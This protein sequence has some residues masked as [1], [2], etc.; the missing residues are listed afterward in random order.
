VTRPL[1][2]ATALAARLGPRALV[3]PCLAFEVVPSPRPE[4]PGA[5]LLVASPRA[6]QAL[7][8]AGLDPTWRV[9]AL[10]PATTVALRAVGLPV[11]HAVEGGGAELARAARPGPVICATSDIGGDEVLRVRP[12]AARWVLYRTVCPATLPGEA[13]AATRGVFDVLFTSPSAVRNFENLAPGA[14]AKAR[15]VLCF[16]ATTCA[17][18]EARGA[19][20]EPTTLR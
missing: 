18:V 9:L 20:A 5:D 6:A 3:A 12:D 7:A 10:A 15:R 1:E 17:E 2:E 16:G 13:V 4:L 8:A 11:H 19:I 14:L